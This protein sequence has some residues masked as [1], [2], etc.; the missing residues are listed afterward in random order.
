M[1]QLQ[2][3]C[4]ITRC[5]TVYA[6]LEDNLDTRE[7]LAA[8]GVWARQIVTPGMRTY[9]VIFNL[10]SSRGRDVCVSLNPDEIELIDHTINRQ[11][12]MSVKEFQLLR[13]RFVERLRISGM[14]RQHHI[15]TVTMAQQLKKAEARFHNLL[16]QEYA[17]AAGFSSQWI[18]EHLFTLL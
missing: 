3:R 16:L 18:E 5:G 9:S 6:Y 10:P 7:L 8:W 1:K 12:Q 11:R 2:S 4:R 14:A 17:D 13:L 15:R